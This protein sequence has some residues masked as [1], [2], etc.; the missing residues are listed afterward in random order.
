MRSFEKLYKDYVKAHPDA[1]N[2]LNYLI[3]Y[4]ISGIMDILKKLRGRKII[5]ENNLMKVMTL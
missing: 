2:L 1:Q 4:G 5:F 3:A